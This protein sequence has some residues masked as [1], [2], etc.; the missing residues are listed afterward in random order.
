MDGNL[1][2][3]FLKQYEKIQS[4]NEKR[5]RAKKV[6]FENFCRDFE[7]IGE[8]PENYMTYAAHVNRDGKIIEG[9]SHIS[10]YLFEQF[11]L[12]KGYSVVDFRVLPKTENEKKYAEEQK[13]IL[14]R[15]EYS[16]VQQVK[17]LISDNYKKFSISDRF[18]GILVYT[19]KF[20]FD[21]H[22]TRIEKNF[23]G[24]ELK[25]QITEKDYMVCITFTIEKPEKTFK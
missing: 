10:F 24:R 5:E 4:E 11:L 16:L 25:I 1:K 12:S 7:K 23:I 20:P 17:D 6:L 2:E 18:D 9:F 22:L 21:K 19:G 14:L 3:L 15:E 13:K 8:I